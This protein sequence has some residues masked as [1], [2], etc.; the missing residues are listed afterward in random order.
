MQYEILL[1]DL[2]PLRLS[3]RARNHA[4]AEALRFIVQNGVLPLRN[5]DL[6]LVEE[7]FKR[8]CPRA[9]HADALLALAVTELR[10]A[11]KLVLF[12]RA[13]NKV[14]ALYA[15]TVRIERAFV[16]VGNVENIMLQIFFDNEPSAV[17]AALSAEV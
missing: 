5:C 9:F 10:L 8:T 1:F 2:I 14:K 6:R 16:A 4:A 7:D 12:G 3:E 13:R 15:A 11:N 17:L